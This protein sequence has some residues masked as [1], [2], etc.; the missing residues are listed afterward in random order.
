VFR[1]KQG[2]PKSKM[3][4]ISVRNL[5]I[6]P[7]FVPNPRRVLTYLQHLP[8]IKMFSPLSYNPSLVHDGGLT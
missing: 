3:H 1:R 7:D 5:S 6:N 2:L 8:T 4:F